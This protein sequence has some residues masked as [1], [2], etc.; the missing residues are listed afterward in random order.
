MEQKCLSVIIFKKNEVQILPQNK[1]SDI[2]ID[3]NSYHSSVFHDTDT[4]Y[5]KREVIYLAF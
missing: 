1:Q 4:F 3:K 2:F 5:D